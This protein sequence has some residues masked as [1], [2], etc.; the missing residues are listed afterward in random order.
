MLAS[1]HVVAHPTGV[2]ILFRQ[3]GVYE[4]SQEF[5]TETRNAKLRATKVSNLNTEIMVCQR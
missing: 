4:V 1:Q 5:V 3:L 2:S